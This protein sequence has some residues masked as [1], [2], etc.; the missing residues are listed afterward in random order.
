MY[1]RFLHTAAPKVR[2]NTLSLK[3][4]PVL[5]RPLFFW[6][7]LRE[8]QCLRGRLRA[9]KPKMGPLLFFFIRADGSP[10]PHQPSG[11]CRCTPCS[12]APKVRNNTLSLKPASVLFR[13]LFF[14]VKLR[15]HQCLRDRLRAPKPKM[16]PLLF[17]FIRAD[18]SPDPH[19]PFHTC[20]CTLW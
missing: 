8:H 6:V 12:A 20:R 15:E 2:N 16:G 5:F 9:P 10:D 13:P 14:W 18:G 11:T 19:Q 17:F 7:K 4:T 3:R 1:R